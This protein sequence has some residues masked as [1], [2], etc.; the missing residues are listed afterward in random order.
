[1]RYNV[2]TSSLLNTTIQ[3]SDM[4]E[5][6]ILVIV[7]NIILNSNFKKRNKNKNKIK[8]IIYNFDKISSNLT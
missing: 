1:M 6:Y 5:R 7:C 3:D 8:S 2:F 4:S